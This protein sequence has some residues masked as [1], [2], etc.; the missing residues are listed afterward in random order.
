[1]VKTE[2]PV[3]E[4]LPSVPVRAALY[5]RNRAEQWYPRFLAASVSDS[6]TT[7]ASCRGGGREACACRLEWWS[8]RAWSRLWAGGVPRVIPAALA[9]GGDLAA[10]VDE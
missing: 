10:G 2:D 7:S 5:V 3:P 1:M 8:G 9:G 6:D 4:H